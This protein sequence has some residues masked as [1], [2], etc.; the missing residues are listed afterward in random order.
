MIKVRPGV[1]LTHICGESVLVAAY[2]AR[3]YC[4]YTTILNDTGDTIWKCLEDGKSLTEIIDYINEEFAV[5]KDTDLRKM[6]TEYIE[7]LHGNGYVL[8]EEDM[9]I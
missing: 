8:Y 9:Q 3:R 7:L 2:E 6:I 4:P 1:V 5:P